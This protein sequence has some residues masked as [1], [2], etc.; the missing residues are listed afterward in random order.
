MPMANNFNLILDT[1]GPEIMVFAPDYTV[2]ST[3]ADYEIK[4]NERLA[5][6]QEFYF[7]DGEG[8]R[9]DVIFQYNGDSFLGWVDFGQFPEGIAV[10]YAQVFD[11]LGNPSPVVTHTILIHQRAGIDVQ[12]LDSDRRKETSSK[13]RETDLVAS[14]R[15]LDRVESDRKQE[16]T[17]TIRTLEA[18][19]EIE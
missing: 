9:H 7:L 11:E 10:F 3:L 17:A 15:L 14:S 6:N 18:V 16:S 12:L 4:A 5:V 19:A 13:G 2:K 1:T 8:K